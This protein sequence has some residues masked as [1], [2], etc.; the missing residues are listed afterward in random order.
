MTKIND[1]IRGTTRIIQIPV[2]QA[3]GTTPYDL[4]GAT[5]YLTLNTSD[6]PADDTS[7]TLQ[8]VV[9]S[10]VVPSGVPA[11]SGYTV[12]QDTASAGISWVKIAPIDTQSLS[13]DTYNYDIQVTDA[14]GNVI[15]KKK[16]KFTINA[17]I[18]RS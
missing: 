9:T 16:D 18:T 5:V 10:H 15:Q 17:E 8:K 11:S 2:T 7:A 14:S 1:Y 6:A 12:G 3:D 4:T 13:P